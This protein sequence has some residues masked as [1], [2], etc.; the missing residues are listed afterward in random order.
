MLSQ[1]LYHLRLAIVVLTTLL[2]SC[3]SKPVDVRTVLPADA[4]V[5]LESRDLGAA[6]G[7]ITES[8]KF[9]ALAKTKPDLSYLNRV[10]IGIAITGFE[11]SEQKVTEE[12]SVLNFQPRF[13][14]AVETRLWNFQAVAFT[15]ERLGS[16]INDVYGGEVL[17]E[18]SEKHGGRYYVWTSDDGRKAYGL[19]IGSLILFGNDESALEKCLA[20]RRGEAESIAA[21]PR[22]TRQNRDLAFGF[23]SPDGIAQISNLA[24]ISLAKRAGEDAEVQSFIARV[25][26]EL[27]RNSLQEITWTATKTDQGIEDKFDVTTSPEVA[28]VFNETITPGEGSIDG[29][30]PFLKYAFES[31]TRYNIADP[32]LGWRSLLLTAQKQ[33][34]QLAGSLIA[35]F[36]DSLFEPY[37]IENGELFLAS[38]GSQIV[39]ARYTGG[40]QKQVVLAEIKNV[41]G[42][43]QSVAKELGVARPPERIMDA[44]VWRSEDGEALLVLVDGKVLL[45]DPEAVL[46]C[47]EHYRGGPDPKIALSLDPLFKATAPA[48]T[49]GH[50]SDIAQN[51]AS[52]LSEPKDPNAKFNQSYFTETRFVRKGIERRTVS[53]FGLIG[54]IISQFAPEKE[55]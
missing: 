31:V 38:V 13:V 47:L 40:E 29:F 6:L 8:E 9:Q 19:V 27:L 11:T 16:F 12:N 46:R 7:S 52:V 55:D 54:T 17:L 28:T 2:V 15:E 18:S 10:E 50:D 30:A 20:V 3:S 49:L 21:N 32:R 51:L 22:L 25:L 24:G 33:T 45:G 36:A 35:G 5:F 14:A 53:D 4:L 34:D 42:I 41:D 26:P 1:K 48:T 37:G 44:E 43:K 23:V 39:T